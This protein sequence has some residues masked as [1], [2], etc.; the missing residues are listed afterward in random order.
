MRQR[1]EIK[2]SNSNRDNRLLSTIRNYLPGAWIAPKNNE[3][4]TLYRLRYRMALEERKYDAALIFLN[5]ILE[6]DPLN[7]EAKLCKGEIY[8]R[9]LQDYAKAVE[10]YNKVLRITGSKESETIHLRARAGMAEIMELL[11]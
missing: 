7:A 3:L 8:H 9:C 6:L 5:K 4:I 1:L 10:Q 11:S 2:R